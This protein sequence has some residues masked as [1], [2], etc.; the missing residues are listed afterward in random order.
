M[1]LPLPPPSPSAR[2]RI[3]GWY[4]TSP[5]LKETD[6][7]IHK[8]L[9]GLCPDPV[10]V[11]CE[12]KPRDQGLPVHAYALREDPRATPDAPRRAFANL[13]TE[14]GATEAE[15]IGVEHLLRDVKD[16]ASS[17]LSAK[18]AGMAAGLTGLASRLREAQGYL[19]LVLAGKLPPNHKVLARLQDALALLPDLSDAALQRSFARQMNDSLAL[20]YLG[21]LLRAVLALHSLIE[22]KEARAAQAEERKNKGK[23]KDAANETNAATATPK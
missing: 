17:T 1:S 13:R 2:E 11:I 22:N 20:V 12:V 10:L 19:E 16:A 15:E 18:V 8:V 4:H 23:K 3:V 9:E 6:P 5:R 7:L 14:V 21:A